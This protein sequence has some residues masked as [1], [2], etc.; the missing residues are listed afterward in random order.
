VRTSRYRYTR[1]GKGR[2]SENM[3]LYDRESDPEEMINLIRDPNYS[4][5]VKKMSALLDER[6]ADAM[7]APEGLIQNTYEYERVIPY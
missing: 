6:I 3:E 4:E 1:W 2:G 7:E 5:T